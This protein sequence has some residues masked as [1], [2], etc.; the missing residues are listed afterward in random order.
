MVAP[1]ACMIIS[2]SLTE[3][4]VKGESSG[5]KNKIIA[6]YDNCNYTPHKPWAGWQHGK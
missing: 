6:H 1:H 3:S 5:N 4:E 2:I